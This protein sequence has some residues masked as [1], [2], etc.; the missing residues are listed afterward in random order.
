LPGTTV[1][2]T[3]SQL[4]A[5]YKNHGQFVSAWSQATEAAHAAGFLVGADAE[6]LQSAATHSDIGK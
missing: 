6:E 1:P 3:P 4:A 2:F 5:L